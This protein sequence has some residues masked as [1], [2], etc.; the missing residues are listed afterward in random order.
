MEKNYLCQ[1]KVLINSCN[2]Y[3]K[4]FL[5]IHFIKRYGQKYG[6]LSENSEPP[7]DKKVKLR[8]KFFHDYLSW[9]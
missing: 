3:L 8:P 2:F 1:L 6:F 4:H 7:L 9:D 5:K